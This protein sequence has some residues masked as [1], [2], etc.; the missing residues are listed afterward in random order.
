MSVVLYL[1]Y[2]NGYL[3]MNAKRAIMYVG[4]MGNRKA[5]FASCTGY[6]K[7]VIK[8]RESKDVQFHFDLKL[9]KGDVT[10]ELLDAAKECILKLDRSNTNAVIPI[11]AK[12]RY[13]LV[14]RFKSASGS[15]L[16]SWE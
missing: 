3:P 15:Y 7:R 10:M 16:L 9:S 5:T 1:L 13:Y 12:K 8:F 11:D 2:I 14:F 4:F 6:T